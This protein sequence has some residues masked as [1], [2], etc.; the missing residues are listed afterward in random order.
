MNPRP[1]HYECVALPLSYCGILAFLRSTGPQL[2]CNREPDE[3][4]TRLNSPGKALGA[5]RGVPL[6][7]RVSFPYTM[8]QLGGNLPRRNAAPSHPPP[9]TAGHLDRSVDWVAQAGSTCHAR[10]WTA[11]LAAC[12][13]AWPTAALPSLPLRHFE[14]VGYGLRIISSTSNKRTYIGTFSS[15]P[16][17]SETTRR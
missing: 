16:F 7:H 14:E 10:P 11:M 8:S 5:V 17:S 3:P 6:A 15:C 4:V 13:R 12:W 1:T 2:V 9:G